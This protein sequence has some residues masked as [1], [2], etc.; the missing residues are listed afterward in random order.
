MSALSPA[1]A[2]ACS[3]VPGLPTLIG[4]PTNDAEAVPTNV[5]LHYLV[6][7]GTVRFEDPPDR[8]TGEYTL[9]SA[10]GEQVP[11]VVTRPTRDLLELTP[12]EALQPN[13]D[14]TLEAHWELVTG[15]EADTALTFLTGDGPNDATP[16]PPAAVLRG[17]Q[18]KQPNNTCAP[19]KAGS[20]VSVQDDTSLIEYTRI[21]E[22]GAPN[23]S[24]FV[25]G[26][27]FFGV[28]REHFACI[29]V[30]QFGANGARSQALRLCAEDAPLLD[31]TTLEGEPDVGCS[32]AGLQWCVSSGKSGIEPGPDDPRGADGAIYCSRDLGI[33]SAES[34]QGVEAAAGSALGAP[35]PRMLPEPAA[36]GCSVTAVQTSAPRRSGVAIL[37][38]LGLLLLRRRRARVVGS[39]SGCGG[40]YRCGERAAAS[41]AGVA[42]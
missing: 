4:Q 13:T 17:Y 12:Q 36:D 16:P 38:S 40:A 34:A 8:V 41:A 10:S 5:V 29:D 39:R 30:R 14:Y 33:G 3:I 7:P 23:G 26:S 42:R 31:I 32:A 1:P 11:L 18:M 21:D 27:S 15:Q 19:P 2:S 22:N 25:R 9:R 20:C 6:P 24:S 35:I 37:V 28:L